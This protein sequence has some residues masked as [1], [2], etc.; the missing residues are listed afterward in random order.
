MAFTT[1]STTTEGSALE[2][3]SA[4][5]IYRDDELINTFDNPAVG[6][7]LSYLDSSVAQGNHTYR[8]VAFNGKAEGE[9]A[10]QNIYFGVDT[11]LKVAALTAA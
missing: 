8:V 5:K 3:L 4:V 1:P 2:S 7:A 6:T 11:P 10:E 9:K